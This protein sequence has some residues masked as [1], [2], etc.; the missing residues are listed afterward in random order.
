MENIRITS[1]EPKD[2]LG[3]PVKGLIT[4]L[5]IKSKTRPNKYKKSRYS[6]GNF[7]MNYLSNIIRDFE[8]LPYK[9]Y[10]RRRN[11]HEPND[12]YFYLTRQLT[13]CMTKADAI[14]SNV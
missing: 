4:S 9:S 3:R 13:K 11:K 1:S 10:E 12:S 7:S 5:G 14:N 8:K 6:I 2:N